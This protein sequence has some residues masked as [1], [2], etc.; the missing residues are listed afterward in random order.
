MQEML[1]DPYTY[2]LW[3]Y[4]CLNAMHCRKGTLMPGDLLTSYEQIIA[5]LTYIDFNGNEKT[6]S[7]ATVA[8]CLKRLKDLG[9][10]ECEAKPGIGLKIHVVDWPKSQGRK[11]KGYDYAHPT[12][13]LRS[14]YD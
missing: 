13:C 3:M 2:K 6:Y 8:K 7:R 9:W 14:I 11:P 12:G 1:L 4:I 10:I 5:S